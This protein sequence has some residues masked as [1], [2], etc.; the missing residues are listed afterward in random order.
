VRPTSTKKHL[1][2]LLAAAAVLSAAAPATEKQLSIYAPVATYTLPVQDRAGREYVGLLEL[3]EPLGRVSSDSSGSR[4]RIR[5]NAVDAE[6]TAGKTRCKIH[7]RDFDLTA[8]FQLENSRGFVPVAS[9]TTLLPRFLGTPVNFHETARRLFVGDVSIQPS[10]QLETGPPS[11]LVLN[12]SAPVNPTIATEPG[13]LRMIF[14]RDAV[15]SPGSQSISFDDKVITQ[16]KY[17]ENNGTAEFE[18]DAN[19]PLFA[20][21][22]NG[23]KTI[24]LAAAPTTTA[25]SPSTPAPGATPP[26]ASPGPGGAPSPPRRPLA[27]VDP[28][29]GGDERGAALADNLAEKD[30]TLGFARLLRHELEVHGFA[31]MLLRD[32]DN[33]LTVDQRAGSANTQRASVY[34]CLHATSQG[35]GARVYTALLPVEAPSKGSFRAWNSAQSHALPAS[36]AVA[37]AVVNELQKKEFPARTS[38]ASVKPLTNVFMPAIAVE[39][40]PGASGLA[41]LTSANYQQQAAAAIADAVNATRD[42]LGVQQ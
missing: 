40:A 19:S 28:A 1:A 30:I 18:I 21:F 27:I 32:G 38:P 41:D 42:R 15:V 20:S 17:S 24:T 11:K 29:H 36:R 4:W 12:F 31:V 3:L 9:L 37:S 8:P 13:H 26:T 35:N 2:L 10:F 5:Y 23:G 22:S 34:I 39:L 14:K 25:S 16:A 33:N 7:G 6:F